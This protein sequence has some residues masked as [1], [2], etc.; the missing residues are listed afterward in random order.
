MISKQAKDFIGNNTILGRN[1]SVVANELND[2]N[3]GLDNSLDLHYAMEVLCNELKDEN[4]FNSWSL[5][6]SESFIKE[7]FKLYNE[8]AFSPQELKE[9]I[10]IAN[11]A[12]DNFLKQLMK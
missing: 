3:Q 6:I 9:L 5:D 2:I 1:T 10:D 7:Y 4:Y 8:E 12:A 11:K